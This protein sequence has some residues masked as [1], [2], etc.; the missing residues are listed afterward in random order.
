MRIRK[1]SVR[2][3][4]ELSGERKILWRCHPTAS[5]PCLTTGRPHQAGA[6]RPTPA[7][8]LTAPHRGEGLTVRPEMAAAGA[9]GSSPALP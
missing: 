4:G 5:D 3:P 9:A 6:S 7:C 2:S 8:G 1:L